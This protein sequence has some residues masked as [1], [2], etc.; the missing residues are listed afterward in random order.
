MDSESRSK[1]ETP[2]DTPA[3]EN[4]KS[5]TDSR[6]FAPNSMSQ[7]D[8]DFLQ[9]SESVKVSFNY[10]GLH[11][12]SKIK[13]VNNSTSDAMFTRYHPKDG[14]TYSFGLQDD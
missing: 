9:T 12:F 6:E 14:K 5:V 2:S 13:K 7:F 3:K 10:S 1:M 11:N 4:K 8:S